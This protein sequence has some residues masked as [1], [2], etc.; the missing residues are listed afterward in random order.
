MTVIGIDAGYSRPG[1]SVV[2]FNRDTWDHRGSELVFSG[3]FETER[4]AGKNTKVAVDDARRIRESC[5]WMRSIVTENRP[6]LVVVEMPLSGG[7]SALAIKG[8]AMA[9]GYTVAIMSILEVDLQFK[10]VYYSPYDTKRV[11]TGDPHAEKEKMIEAA[12]R[13]WPTVQFPMKKTR[14]KGVLSQHPGRSEAMA[15]SLCAILTH[16]RLNLGKP[17]L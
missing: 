2:R 6:N 9:A 10:T 4:E 17:I 11:C 16:V 13:A 7:R 14:S 12:Q 15:D 1:L 8:M 5:H 3:F